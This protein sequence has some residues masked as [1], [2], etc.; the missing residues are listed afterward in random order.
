MFTTLER[1]GTVPFGVETPGQLN[2]LFP[3]LQLGAPSEDKHIV[4]N[5]ELQAGYGPVGEV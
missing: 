1:C 3:T 2:V 5:G 4:P